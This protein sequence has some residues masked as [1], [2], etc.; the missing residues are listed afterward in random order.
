M[1]KFCEKGL[2]DIARRINLMTNVLAEGIRELGHTVK[3]ENYFDTINVELKFSA[4]ELI[5]SAEE[6]K[7]NLR[8]VDIRTIGITLDETTTQENIESLLRAFAS[9]SSKTRYITSYRA[10]TSEVNIPDVEALSIKLG[11]DK[12]NSQ[13]LSIPEKFKRTTAFMEHEVFNKYHS[14]TDMLRYIHQLQAKDVSLIHSMIPLGSCTMK[15]NATAEMFP[16]SWPEFANIHPFVPKSQAGGYHQ[17]LE[18][19]H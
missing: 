15:L 19:F 16:I 10:G 7:I 17:I 4:E 5:R 13:S 12:D 8:K 6:R 14:E 2:K 3:Y 1:S 9:A 18:V 11:L